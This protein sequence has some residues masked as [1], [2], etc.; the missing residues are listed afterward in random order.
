MQRTSVNYSKY[1]Y[2]FCI[3]FVLAFLI[4]S[5]YPILYTA[6]IG[7][8]DLRGLGKTDFHFLAN[9]FENFQSVLNNPSFIKSLQNTGLI[10]IINFIPQIALAL[11]L[12]AW[13]TN[14][15][16]RVKGQGAFKV[17]LYMPNIITA[18]TIAIL[19]NSLFA[20]PM[21]PVNYLA[22]K[23]GFIDAPMNFLLQK[24]TA[25]G[26]VAFIQFWMWYGSTM[27]VLIAGVMGISPTLF[28][29]AAIDGASGIQTFFRITLPSLRT[30]L[31]YTLITSMI[32]GL[33]IFDIP[34]LFLLGG[35][36]NAT[37]TT[38]VFIFN[39]AFSGSYLYNRAAAAS[40]IM[41]LIIG[42]LSAILFYVMRDKDAEK[43]K[44]AKKELARAARRFPS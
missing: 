4:F 40:M 2:I 32:G 27:I 19:F 18:A 26:I 38:S 5:L 30:I 28:E 17:M 29:A 15:R 11:L 25:R 3:P 37:L 21:S 39:Q 36:D 22:V 13:F 20:Y 34:R 24:W 9:P 8:T 23:L 31:L 33:Q 42:V 1:G 41:F 35:P 10:W 44:K 12:T 14:E 7:F 6:V 16:L 43:Q